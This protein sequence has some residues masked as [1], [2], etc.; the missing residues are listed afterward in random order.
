MS[1][2]QRGRIYLQEETDEVARKSFSP[3]SLAQVLGKLFTSS[4]HSSSRTTF[5]QI[6]CIYQVKELFSR[7]TYT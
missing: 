1:I 7:H 2:N 4:P 3:F 5:A 6:L